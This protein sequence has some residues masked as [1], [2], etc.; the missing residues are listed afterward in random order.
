MTG[1]HPRRRLEEDGRGY[2]DTAMK[3]SNRIHWPEKKEKEE[4]QEQEN[5]H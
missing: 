4:Q 1:G 5:T 3:S 2:R